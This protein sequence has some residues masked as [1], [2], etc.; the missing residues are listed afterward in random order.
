MSAYWPLFL[1]LLVIWLINEYILVKIF[2]DKRPGMVAHTWN[3]STLGGWGRQSPEVR[4]S[5]SAWPTWWSPISTKNIKTSWAWWRM[6][7]IPT[8]WESEARESLKPRRWKLQW[9]KIVP[10]H[11]SLGEG[12]R[13][14]LKKKEK[15]F[16]FADF[17]RKFHRNKYPMK[18]D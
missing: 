13:L 2:N 11:S 5:R 7:I 8:T 10:L 18:K 1:K 16:A 17:N 15:L 14:S 3:P 4:S 9:A 6:P 12:V